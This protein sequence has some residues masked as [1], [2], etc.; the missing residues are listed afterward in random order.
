MN[1]LLFEVL[2]WG[3]P[4]G[5]ANMVPVFIKGTHPIDFGKEIRGKRIFGKGKT[6][7]GLISG[8]FIGGIIGLLFGNWQL[9]L[10]IGLGSLLGDIFESFLKRR[11]GIKSGQPWWGFDQLDFV[12]GALILGSFVEPISRTAI[13][14]LLIGMPILHPLANYIGYKLKIKKNKF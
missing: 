12:I 11:V 2:K 1:E 3:V 8:T 10:V 5:L 7:E 14:I 4:M 13:I 9:G 6:L